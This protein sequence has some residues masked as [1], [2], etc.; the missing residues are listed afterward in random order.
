MLDELQKFPVSDEDET[1]KLLNSYISVMVTDTIRRLGWKAQ[2]TTNDGLLQD[3][4]LRTGCSVG[5]QE[6]VKMGKSLFR[7]SKKILIS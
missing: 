2:T 1:G 4:I 6:A 7:Y 5:Q 3:I